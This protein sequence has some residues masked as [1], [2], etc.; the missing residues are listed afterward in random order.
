[1]PANTVAKMRFL[2]F[3]LLALA[4]HDPTRELT[5]QATEPMALLAR[6]GPRSWNH[7]M[8]SALEWL[9]AFNQC[10]W[11]YHSWMFS[12]LW[13]GTHIPISIVGTPLG[14]QS[15]RDHRDNALPSLSSIDPPFL[16]R[17]SHLTFILGNLWTTDVF[18]SFNVNKSKIT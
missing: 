6:Q 3:L 13:E 10:P 1:M 2:I 18:Y 15:C 5:V 17:Y 12:L 9:C 4:E 16:G 8:I 14:P 11:V 7:L